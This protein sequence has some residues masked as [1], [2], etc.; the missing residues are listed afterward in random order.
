MTTNNKIGQD[1]N[2]ID[3]N[4]ILHKLQD[5]KARLN[6]DE[7]IAN[8]TSA[9]N[10]LQA[11]INK[12]KQDRTSADNMLQTAINEEI[13]NRTSA[14]NML[15]TAINEEIANRTSADNILQTT[16]NEEI[17]NRTSADNLL[18][19][20]VSSIQ[21]LIPEQATASNKLADKAFVN[22]SIATNTS[23]FLGT[24]TS[25][26]EIQ[27]LTATNNDY[28]YYI[29]T[30]SSGN[31][32]FKRY[33]YSSASNSWIF[34]YSLNNSSFTSEQ[35][36]AIMSGITAELVE[37]LKGIEEGAQVNTITGV[38][39]DSESSYRT[40]NVNITKD[41]IGL[42]NIVNTSDSATPT[43][44]GTTKFTTGGA[45]TELNK[46]NDKIT[47]TEDSTTALT[48]TD[49]FS[50]SNDTGTNPTKL[51]KR[52][53]SLLWTY[54]KNKADSVY[55]KLSHTHTKSQITDF[56]TSLKN[57]NA[58]TVNGKTYDGSSAINAGIQTVENGGTGN[59]T[60]KD[61]LNAFINSLD[62]DTATP[63]SNDYYVCQSTG[64]G[65][66]DTTYRRRP[67][68]SLWS[69]I[70]TK[71]KNDLG[72]TATDYTGNSATATNANKVSNSLTFGSKIYNGSSAQEITAG[73]LGIST[74]SFSQFCPDLSKI[75]TVQL[76]YGHNDLHL[77]FTV[78]EDGWILSLVEPFHN[79]YST[80]TLTIDGI[81]NSAFPTSFK[82][83]SLSVGN[84]LR[85]C[86]FPVRKNQ[87]LSIST[88]IRYVD[89]EIQYAPCIGN[90]N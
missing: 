14:N 24:F 81:T 10:I 50:T 16:I 64:G 80:V 63:E 90:K 86:P 3:L 36:L 87:I 75:Q 7:E 8:R 15:Q 33:K 28:A 79:N 41:N 19:S 60:A 54:I 21:A 31:T 32:L 23:N 65:T 70:K 13:A 72:L 58:L 20:S 39:G 51:V 55:A 25:L 2:A 68:S 52:P 43:S 46:K 59:S 1:I 67:V 53:L 29:T 77:T 9:D 18:K 82:S 47:I 57:P 6:V 56:P 74:V 89:V 42:G 73:D 45:Y 49:T 78:P 76:V 66:T 34:E 44:G 37:K 84:G 48:D 11:I 5:E 38:K 22:S 71:I 40:G 4:E 69:Y 35:W 62:V 88:D 27:A 30:D 83:W 26:Q 85:N 61:A 17:A 12:E